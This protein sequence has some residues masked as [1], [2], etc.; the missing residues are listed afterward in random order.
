MRASG[1]EDGLKTHISSSISSLISPRGTLVLL[2]KSDLAPLSPSARKIVFDSIGASKVW[3]VSLNT[4]EGTQ[5]FL[6]EFGKAL[7]ER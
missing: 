3:L 5:E 1:A 6:D 7:Q 2:N 4:G